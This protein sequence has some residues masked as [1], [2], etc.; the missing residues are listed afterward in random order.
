[1]DF[2]FHDN[3]FISLNCSFSTRVASRE[4]GKESLIVFPN[5]SMSSGYIH[6]MSIQKVN[7]VYNGEP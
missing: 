4:L 5:G 3:I 7:K 1:M 2:T 6:E